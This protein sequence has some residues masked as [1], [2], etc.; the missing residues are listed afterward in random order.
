MREARRDL[1][2]AHE[3]LGAERGR[4]LG[5]QNLD[6]YLAAMLEVLREIHRGLRTAAQF[7]LDAVAV[8]E[9]GLEASYEVFHATRP[10]LGT[11][12]HYGSMRCAA[13][14]EMGEGYF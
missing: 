1:D 11:P 13:R 4:Q 3:A 8:G 14:V 2:L 12:L 7:P 10:H 5:T 6:R 9:G